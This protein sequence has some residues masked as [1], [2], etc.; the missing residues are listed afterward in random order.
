M[1]FPASSPD[2]APPGLWLSWPQIET[3]KCDNSLGFPADF[4]GSETAALVSH[5]LILLPPG[6][7]TTPRITIAAV[8]EGGHN[9]DLWRGWRKR[10][11]G[12]ALSFANATGKS[13]IEME[14]VCKTFN[15]LAPKAVMLP[16]G[17]PATSFSRVAAT[18]RSPPLGL[19]D[20]MPIAPTRHVAIERSAMSDQTSFDPGR[21]EPRG[22][23][24]RDCCE[25]L[26]LVDVADV[27]A[28]VDII[29]T[30]M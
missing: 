20:L 26:Q 14:R 19:P 1:R 7:P 17:R 16:R 25:D 10:K 28:R 24:D 27:L 23:G 22:S 12:R 8:G 18:G 3:Q 2:L 9:R 30:V 13:R 11:P 15:G 6:S 29:Q 4:A 5:L 21:H